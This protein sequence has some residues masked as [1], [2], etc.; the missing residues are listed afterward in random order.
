MTHALMNG[1]RAA[2]IYSTTFYEV[3]DNIELSLMVCQER[4][5]TPELESPPKYSHIDGKAVACAL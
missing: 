5:H 1:R 4:C 2:V 3:G